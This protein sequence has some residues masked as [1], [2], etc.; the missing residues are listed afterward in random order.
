MELFT[1]YLQYLSEICEGTRKAPVGVEVPEASAEEKAV[2]V[3]QAAMAMGIPAFVRACADAEGR[4]VPQ[5]WYHEFDLAQVMQIAQQ[6]GGQIPSEEGQPEAQET[7]QA[8]QEDTTPKIEEPDGPRNACEV[9]LDCCLLDDNLFSYLME[10]LKTHDALGFFRLSQVT[11]RK[12]IKMEDFLI[13]M[14][15]KEIDAPE[16]ERACVAIMDACL[17]RL[18]DEKEHELLAALMSGDQKTFELFRCDAPEL[19]HLP[20]ATYAW[21]SRNYLDQYYPVRIMM[22]LH[23]IQFPTW[24]G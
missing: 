12:E 24:K 1:L 15:N 4:Q 17:Q 19:K 22:K 20:D 14:G 13:W 21:Y 18:A 16:E 5:Q 3:Q 2:A 11:A 9:L 8:A 23:G 10:V 7:T 6:L